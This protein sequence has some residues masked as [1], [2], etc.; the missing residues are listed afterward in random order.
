M[1]NTRITDPEILERRYPIILRA[2]FLRT[3]SGGQGRFNGGEGVVRALEFRKS[4]QCSI[5][6]ER[7]ALAPWGLHGGSCGAKGLNLLY[8]ADSDGQRSD[9]DSPLSVLG[10]TV[11]DGS[12]GG[13]LVNVGGKRSF[14]VEVGDVFIVE[15]PGGGGYG[16]PV[17]STQEEPTTQAQ[18]STASRIGGGSWGQLTAEQASF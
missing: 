8:K 5:L 14:A 10:F 6:S 18:S 2:F 16:E 13:R 15:T 11:A 3:S 1:T 17:S 7:R 9:A 4:L 12:A